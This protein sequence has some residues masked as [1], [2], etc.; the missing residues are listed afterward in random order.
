MSKEF[1]PQQNTSLKFGYIDAEGK[2]IIPFEYDRMWN[3]IGAENLFVRVR[4]EE[5]YG[6]IRTDGKIILQPNYDSI[7][8]IVVNQQFFICEMNKKFGIVDAENKIIVPFEYNEISADESE[9]KLFF[10]LKKE[11]KYG[12]VDSSGQLF[13]PFEYDS[14]N[15]EHNYLIVEKRKKHSILDFNR[16]LIQ[17][18]KC[19]YCTNYSDNETNKILLEIEYEDGTFNIVRSDGKY[20]LS[21]VKKDNFWGVVDEN[22]KIVVPFKYKEIK[23]LDQDSENL[24]FIA[25]EKYNYDPDIFDGNGK[26]ISSNVGEFDYDIYYKGKYYLLMQHLRYTYYGSRITKNGLIDLTGKIVIKFIYNDLYTYHQDEDILLFCAKRKRKYGVIDIEGNNFLPFEYDNLS[27]EIDWD[28]HSYY[29]LA[30]KNRKWGFMK[31]DGTI[32]FPFII[33]KISKFIYT[34][35][36]YLMGGEINKKWGIIDTFGNTIV[37]FIYDDLDYPQI[38]SEPTVLRLKKEGKWIDVNFHNKLK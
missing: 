11:N 9:T 5:N 28:T 23:V 36:G 21:K 14:I 27:T 38:R 22:Q 34:E 35:E 26:K 33:D 10:T 6:I 7:D 15:I 20:K 29:F 19:K 25:Y 16:K 2:E 32:L 37:P 30:Q 31:W 4:K 3:C 8:L 12:V 13:L 18:F 1:K 24:F 17:S